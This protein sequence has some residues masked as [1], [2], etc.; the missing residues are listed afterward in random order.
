MDDGHDKSRDR[1]VFDESQELEDQVPLNTS[2][3]ATFNPLANDDS[4]YSMK[5]QK[6]QRTMNVQKMS[7]ESQENMNNT[8]HVLEKQQSKDVPS[9][10]DVPSSNDFNCSILNDMNNMS[11]VSF[12]MESM[13]SMGLGEMGQS[14]MNEGIDGINLMQIK[15]QLQARENKIKQLVED[16]QRLKALLVKA[17]GAI[18]KINTQYK[19]AVEENRL[20]EQKL[21]HT[22]MEKQTMQKA[23]EDMQKRRNGIEKSQVSQI[24]ARVKVGEIGYTLIQ[25]VQHCC[26]WYR[27]NMITHVQEQL[28]QEW[29]T[30]Q[31]VNYSTIFSEKLQLED[32]LTLCM[33]QYEERL[34]RTN[35]YLEQSNQG[36]QQVQEEMKVMKD[37]TQ[38]DLKNKDAFLSELIKRSN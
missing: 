22:N 1:R 33:N 28:S 12:H 24:L 15:E 32:S 19:T 10:S 16:K 20:S 38:L 30:V 13:N 37:K 21:L 35:E 9:N 29:K 26:E 17:K 25:D 27:D 5:Q 23:L 14:I 4:K 18:A 2:T 36:Y 7:L 11:M 3:K 31:Q 34:R 6:S 8:P